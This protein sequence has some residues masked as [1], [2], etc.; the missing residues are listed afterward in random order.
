VTLKETK[1]ITKKIEINVPAN[2]V[3]QAITDAKM[4]EQWTGMPNNI[5]PELGCKFEF[6]ADAE[7]KFGDW[8]RTM[9]CRITELVENKKI[10]FTLQLELMKGETLVT[11]ALDEKD[12][13]TKLVLT[14]SGFESDAEKGDFWMENAANGW[15]DLLSRLRFMLAGNKAIKPVADVALFSGNK[16]LL[17]KYKEVNKY[18]H[19]RGWFIP[20]DL[21]IHAEHPDDASVRILKE[22]LGAENLSP[23][24]AFIESFIGGDK[25]WHL[26]FHYHVSVDGGIELKPSKEIAEMRWFDINSLPDKKEIAHHGWAKYILDE[27]LNL[28]KQ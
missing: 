11:I 5:K 27:I 18:D 10:S 2:S 8:D 20:D 28:E 12:G 1:E 22:Q 26:I 13:I 14:Q 25:S 17:V 21:M 19:Q 7:G 16:T 15:R 9:R 23:V 3:W 4:L 24:L 6:K